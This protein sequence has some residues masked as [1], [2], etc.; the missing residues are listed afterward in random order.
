MKT[1][2]MG[3]RGRCLLREGQGRGNVARNKREGKM[4]RK[5]PREGRKASTNE[6]M[7]GPRRCVL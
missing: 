2:D 7:R 4:N 1:K 6:D 5:K 3:K